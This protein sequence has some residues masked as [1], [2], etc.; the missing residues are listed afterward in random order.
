MAARGRR[1]FS[2]EARRTLL[3]RSQGHPVAPF[4]TS[5]APERGVTRDPLYILAVLCLIVVVSEVLVRRTALRHLGTALVVILVTAVAANLGIVPA[6]SPPDAPVAVYDGIFAYLAPLAI[7]WLVLPISLR[8][9]WKAGPA[10]LTLFMVGAAAVMVGA[11]VG[12]ALFGR[13]DAFGPLQHAL[14][15]MFV[16][17][18]TGGSINFNAVA[19]GYDV[20]EDGALFAGAVVVDNIVTAVWMMATL[21]LPR[22]LAPFW[23]RGTVA[24]GHDTDDA[25]GIGT[26]TEAVHPLDLGLL[27]ALG[28]GAVLVSDTLEAATAAAGWRVPSILILTAL[29]L[30]LAQLPPVAR[31]KGMRVLG[32]FAVYLF[33]AVIGAFC[34]LVRLGEMGHTGILLLGFAATL[35]AVHGALTFGAARILRMDP[36]VA[37]V[38]SQANVGGGTSALAVAR[39]LGRPDLVLP[40]ILVG[41]LGNA[42]GTFLGFWTAALLL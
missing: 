22:L 27:L 6:G 38:A 7:F 3:A 24:D 25:L 17:T 30:V 14:G 10:I 19:I 1:W 9:V 15:G 32:M 2:R 21:A 36:D 20:M 34:D 35:V 37:A 33:L 11:F 40:G 13:G 31:L 41:S 18:Y 5:P 4:L 28:L 29:A 8:E 26:D 16:G 42:I 12:I 39:S 23:T